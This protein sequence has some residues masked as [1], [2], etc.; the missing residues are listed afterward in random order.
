MLGLLSDVWFAW[1][2]GP[3]RAQQKH[4]QHAVT[5]VHNDNCRSPGAEAFRGNAVA[6]SDQP[7]ERSR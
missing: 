3:R 6:Q 2:V 1:F 4:N 5:I 7:R